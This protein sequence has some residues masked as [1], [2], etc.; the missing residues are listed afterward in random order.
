[1]LDR[2]EASLDLAARHPRD[3]A[4]R[5]GPRF[6]LFAVPPAPPPP[7]TAGAAAAPGAR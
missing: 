6:A 1:L 5:Q 2:L 4:A 3:V 7:P